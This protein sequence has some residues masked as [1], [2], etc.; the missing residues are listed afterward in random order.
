MQTPPAQGEESANPFKGTKHKVKVNGRDEE[1]EYE[2]LVE[3]A[4]KYEASDQN[5][6]Q[7][8]QAKRELTELMQGLSKGDQKALQFLLKHTP[9]DAL[10]RLAEERVWRKLEY[11]K[12][13][14]HEKARLRNEERERALKEREDALEN[15]AKSK[16]WAQNVEAAGQMIKSRVDEFYKSSGIEP[17]T[18]VLLRVA[19]YMRS[20]VSQGRELPPMELLHKRVMRDLDRDVGDVLSKT[21]VEKLL[22]RLSPQQA[23][24][25]K[26]MLLS[27]AAAHHPSRH[28][29]SIAKPARKPAKKL[30]IDDAF[31]SLEQRFKRK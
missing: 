22:E 5:F 1:W 12:L 21:P 15:D 31:A 26:K 7:A 8:A 24:A 16:A 20:Q 11:D 10:D 3:R 27:Q 13:P 23:D 25:L 14:E 9:A 17:S 19:E 4:Q 30:G 28:R 18:A 2:R 29:E 6:Q